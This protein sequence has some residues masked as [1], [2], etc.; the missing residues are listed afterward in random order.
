MLAAVKLRREEERA[1]IGTSTIN[2]MKH[3][4]ILNADMN[5]LAVLMICVEED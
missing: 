4:N 5:R 2:A 1:V 3:C